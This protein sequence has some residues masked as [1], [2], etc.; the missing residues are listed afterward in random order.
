MRASQALVT[1]TTIIQQ[2]Y[3][4]HTLPSLLKLKQDVPC[5]VR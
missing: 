4:I 2:L 1:M 3:V 5:T